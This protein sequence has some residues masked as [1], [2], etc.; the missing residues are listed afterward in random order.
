[1][2]S[3]HHVGKMKTARRL[4]GPFIQNAVQHDPVQIRV[5][6]HKV[7]HGAVL[8]IIHPENDPVTMPERRFLDAADTDTGFHGVGVV[9]EVADRV[10]TADIQLRVH[11]K[12]TLGDRV[13]DAIR[14]QH[15][16]SVK[17]DPPLETVPLRDGPHRFDAVA[18]LVLTAADLF[19]DLAVNIQI[20]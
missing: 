5:L 10:I 12:T 8:L 9:Q 17:P 2:I 14:H 7:G 13:K 15:F 4:N 1:M 20:F 6:L 19:L 11:I 16:H 3:Q 18:R